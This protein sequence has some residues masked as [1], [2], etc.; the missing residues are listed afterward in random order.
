MM[1]SA[2]FRAVARFE[3]RYQLTSP[4]FLVVAV[5][6]F[7]LAFGNMVSD[8]VQLAAVGNVKVNSPDAITQVH[9]V[10]SIIAL[11]VVTAL[12]ANIVLR[13]H[14]LR[15]SELLFATQLKKWPYLIGRFVGA[16]GASLAALLFV[17]LGMWVGSLMPAVDPERLGPNQWFHYVYVNATIVAPNLLFAGAFAFS[18]ATLSRSLLLTYVGVVA[19]LLIYGVSQTLLSAPDLRFWA[20]LLDPF[21]GSAYA[22]VTR[23][24]T[25]YERNAQ[26]IPLSGEFALNRLL[27]TGLS[28]LL[29]SLTYWRF[30]MRLN[31]SSILGVWRWWRSINRD[32]ETTPVLRPEVLQQGAVVIPWRQFIAQ[33]RF[34]FV[35]ILRSLPFLVL[36]ALAVLSTYL[37]FINLNELFGTPV[38]PLTRVLTNIMQGTFTLSLLIVVIY[39]GAELVWREQ[40]FRCHE[41]IDVCPA[42]SWVFVGAKTL[43]LLLV[44]VSLLLAGVV[45]AVFYQWSQGFTEFQWSVYVTR[46]V[47]DYGRLFYCAA[48][49]SLFVQNMVKNKFIGMAIMVM[50]VVV[51]L[52]AMPS[53][54]FEDPLYRFGTRAD[55]AYSDFYGWG[56]FAAIAAWYALYW[57]SFCVLLYLASYLLWRRGA[58]G[59]WSGRWRSA[60]EGFSRPA[61]L[62]SCVALFAFL[63]SGAYIFYN[64]R[65]LN[66]YFNAKDL[67]ASQVRYEQMYGQYELEPVPRIVAVNAQVDI[68]PRELR[69]Q[70]NG[71][72]TLENR[73]SEAIAELNVGI[74]PLAQLQSIELE[75]GSLI[76]EDKEF[77]V[78]RYKLEPAL[79]P[80]EKIQVKFT[81]GRAIVGFKHSRNNSNALGLSAL[82]ENGSFIFNNEAFPYLGF[83]RSLILTDRSARKRYDLPPVDRYADLDDRSQYGNS[84]LRQDSDWLAFEATVSTDSGQIAIAPGYLEREWE[85]DGRH[86]F[87]YQMDAPMQNLFAFLSADYAQRK[88]Q[89]EGIDLEVFYHPQH[90]FNVDKM[91]HALKQSLSYF[92][93]EFSPYQYRQ[94]R[95]IE[96]PA[97]AG[98]FAVSFPNTVPWSEGL[99]FIANV[100]EPTDIDYV[101]YVGAHEVAHQWWGH[102][103]SS[104]N[105]QG[106]TLLVETLAQY[107]AL[108]VMEQE[109]GPHL[110]RRFLKYELDNYL[111]NRGNEALEE[112]PLYRVE[113]QPYVHYRKGSLVMYALKDYLGEARVNQA[114]S[115]FIANNAYHYDPYPSAW[116]LLAEL[117]AVAENEQE[118]ELI[119]D[120]FQRITLWDLKVTD[121]TVEAREDG[122]FNVSISVEAQ[123]LEADGFGEEHQR[124]MHMPIDIG[125]F[126][127]S[128]DR[129]EFSADEVIYLQKEWIRH[130]ASTFHFTVDRAPVVVGIDPYN[131]LIDRNAED[132][133][134]RVGE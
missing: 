22:N 21:G 73:T 15:A 79:E 6:F 39:Y 84:Y 55:V 104:A 123:R 131:K 24:W 60:V 125:M 57:G 10:M 133:L 49:L 4:V 62:V 58:Q 129:A 90:D 31:P 11:F 40:Q 2:L 74:H 107:S 66:P 121:T 91:L 130:G 116:D 87:H 92:S 20:G 114:L 77:N 16:Y 50:Y 30:Q 120:L 105:V 126:A 85:E 94:M 89:W 122:R 113:N 118:L 100:S 56:H 82:H 43:A 93:R 112:L 13:D 102:Q 96:F 134:R 69:Y 41:L 38:Y 83:D 46:H 86:Y 37:S 67:E 7:L 71:E 42:P 70:V 117:K 99:G 119:D 128:P 3:F 19:F 76:S 95:V 52:F 14:E 32:P 27:W 35:H 5:L 68:F 26:L 18:L 12:M 17:S 97:S 9:L 115:N 8:N 109:Y 54:G 34:E 33:L 108:M 61:Q 110:M 45:T 127:V 103:V 36:L 28:L 81:S 53:L 29:I 72:Y 51:V 132:N 78:Y 111:S 44:I 59:D 48:I 64:T 124:E 106:Q 47:L 101:F 88:E 1:F 65:I 80:G 98:N 25:A 23:Y 75:H 63:A